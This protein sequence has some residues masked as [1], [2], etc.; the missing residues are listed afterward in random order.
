MQQFLLDQLLVLQAKKTEEREL[1]IECSTC[2]RV[3]ENKATAGLDTQAPR[4][5]Q[6]DVGLGLAVA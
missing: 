2:Q 3:L 5:Q 4:S 1:Y 6:I